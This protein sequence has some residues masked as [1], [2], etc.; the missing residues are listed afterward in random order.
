MAI[1]SSQIKLIRSLKDKKFRDS[2]GLFVVEGE[3]MVQEAIESGYSIESVFRTS[4]IGEENM[5]RISLLN[6]PSP[7]LA[8]V[9]MKEM[10]GVTSIERGGLYLALDAIRDPGNMGTILRLADW[11]GVDTVFASRDSVDIFN[12]KVVQSTMGAIFRVKFL[13]CDLV[14][15]LRG[16]EAE[17]F[18]TFLNGENIYSAC[19]DSDKPRVIV[20]GNEANGISRS[21]SECCNRRL[22]IP[23]FAK[24]SGSESLNAA[25]ATAVTVS[26]FRRRFQGDILK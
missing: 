8:V 22:T 19:L 24:G 1:T 6:T 17:V 26:E 14:T 5:K 13:Y 3:K 7:V 16:C 10:S 9:H 25:I 15:L 21:V 20:I 2:G 23:S 18:G 11:F 12:P 4:E